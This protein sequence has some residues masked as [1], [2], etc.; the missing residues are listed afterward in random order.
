MW[1]RCFTQQPAAVFASWS[2][3]LDTIG[4]SVLVVDASGSWKGMAATVLPDGGLVVQD[5]GGDLKT[6]YAADVSIRNP[7]DYTG[8]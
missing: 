8:P 2:A 6:V 3:R 5:D 7:G 1:Y 4:Q